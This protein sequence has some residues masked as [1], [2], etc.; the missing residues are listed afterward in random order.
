[1]F[2]IPFGHLAQQPDFPLSENRAVAFIQIY[3]N[4]QFAAQSKL[5]WVLRKF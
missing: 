3:R 5:L 4:F 2:F 1:M